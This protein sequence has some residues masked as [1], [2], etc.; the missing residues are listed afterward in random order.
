MAELKTIT[1]NGKRFVLVPEREYKRLTKAASSPPPL[2]PADAAG[3]RN[4]V[5]FARATI[6]RQLKADREAAGLSQ[7]QLARASGVRQ[8]TI[9][10]IESAKV[11]A[12][13]AVMEKLDR[14]I[15]IAQAAKKDPSPAKTE[16]S[17][18]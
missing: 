9:S 15:R 16:M 1:K 4:A 11:S 18:R 7:Q 12:T 3:N 5:D 6:A 2:P 8:E 13:I 14:E 10:R 17:P